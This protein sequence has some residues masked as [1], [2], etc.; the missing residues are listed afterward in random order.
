MHKTLLGVLALLCVGS[1]L[2]HGQ[3]LLVNTADPSAVTFTGTGSFASA[4]YAVTGTT[5][6]PIRLA[7]F[8]TT[9]QT[10]FDS[11]ASST[12]LMTTGAGH[13]LGR[14]FLRVGAGGPT[15]L[16]LRQ[17]GNSQELF[18]TGSAAFTGSATYDLSS[19]ASALPGSGASGNIYA[20]DNTTLIGTYL[21]T[22]I[23]EPATYG[24]AAGL[25]CLG[26]V[27]LRKRSRS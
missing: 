14:A 10:N 7:S 13:T 16:L 11:L 6:F 26:F 8:F 23:P 18:S 1:G 4:D 22:A 27:A 2:A 20:A 9:D 24:V 5:A 17:D 3:V 15:T 12:T 21:I 19:V 25:F